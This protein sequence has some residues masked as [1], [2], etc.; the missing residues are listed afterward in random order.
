M[1][2]LNKKG[3]RKKLHMNIK[4]VRS[5]LMI[6]IVALIATVSMAIIGL[7]NNSCP[8]SL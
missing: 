7:Y 2:E 3:A 8:N 1:S 5:I 4:I 6:W